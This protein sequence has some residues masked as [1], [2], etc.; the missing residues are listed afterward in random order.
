MKE[1]EVGGPNAQINVKTAEKREKTHNGNSG[2]RT[3]GT[4]P[5]QEREKDNG[6]I[7]DK[8]QQINLNR[9]T[10]SGVHDIQK[11][12]KGE[13]FGAKSPGA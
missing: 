5:A 8:Q 11:G 4:K 12:T 2:R 9:L 1:R 10:K 13:V 6:K 7:E 3:E